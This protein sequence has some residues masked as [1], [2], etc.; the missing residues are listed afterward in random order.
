[1]AVVGAM[2]GAAVALQPPAERTI[3]TPAKA[4][5]PVMEAR[6]HWFRMSTVVGEPLAP[7]QRNY[8]ARTTATGP[9]LLFLPATGEQPA[10]YTTFLHLA[11]RTGYHVLGLDYWNLGRS[12]ASTCAAD[13]ACYGRLQ[14]NRFD[15]SHPFAR[16]RVAARDSVLG[17]LKPALAYLERTDPTGGWGRYL[18]AHGVRWSRI[19]VAG[20]SQGGGE[21]AY[22]AHIRAVRGALLFGSPIVTDGPVAATWLSAPGRTP[23]S[24]IY[25][26]DDTSDRFWPRIEAS[27]Q[28]LGL[29]HP[30]VV[31][32]RD[33]YAGHALISEQV[34]AHAH[35]WVLDDS[36]P[37]RADGTPV[38]EPVWTWMLERFAPPGSARA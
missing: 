13:A 18:D 4:A 35:R 11:T 36:T 12:V 5:A 37:R 24:R 27:W 14:R 17:R 21:S 22:I 25:A 23:A 19:V 31:D 15:G 29:G 16:S 34:Q 7:N 10:D 32:G 8:A 26:F 1:M 20:H 28:R 2:I 3:V 6:P 38:D 9:L 30:Q 33:S